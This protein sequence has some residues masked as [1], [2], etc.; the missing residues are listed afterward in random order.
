MINI[1]DTHNYRLRTTLPHRQGG[2]ALIAVT[3][4]MITV[5]TIVGIT[6]SKSSTIQT[7]IATNFVE[8]QKALLAADSAVY[9]AWDQVNSTF[10]LDNFVQNCSKNGTFDLRNSA[11]TSCPGSNTEGQ[12]TV[13]PKTLSTW[14]ALQSSGDWSWGDST[15][16]KSMPDPIATQADFLPNSEQS[17]PMKLVAPP[18]YATGIHE[19]VLRKGTENYHCIPLSV[20]GA[21]KGAL[22]NAQA[23]VEINAI[24]KSSCFRRM[25]H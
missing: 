16:H 24:P 7:K 5:L 3:I 6:A 11:D 1:T 14:S 20:M 19:P 12:D 17:N 22:G 9:Y 23:L 21:G 10:S 18:Q 25:V 13:Q 2:A 4:I 15:M 8:K